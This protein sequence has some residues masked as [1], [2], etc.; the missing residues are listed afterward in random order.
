M[1]QDDRNVG[2]GCGFVEY[3]RVGILRP[4]RDRN[5]FLQAI[6]GRRK[7]GP[8]AVGGLVVRDRIAAGESGLGFE[9]EHGQE[10]PKQQTTILTSAFSKIALSP[11]SASAYGHPKSLFRSFYSG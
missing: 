7:I 11:R 3:P 10:R 2:G 6:T 4:V 8:L 9:N 1:H 5:K